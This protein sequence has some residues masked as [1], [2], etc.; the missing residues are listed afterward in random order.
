MADVA[1]A[2]EESGLL[3]FPGE[4]VLRRLIVQAAGKDPETVIWTRS[5]KHLPRIPYYPATPEQVFIYRYLRDRYP[6]LEISRPAFFKGNHH[7]KDQACDV[8]GPRRELFQA[9]AQLFDSWPGGLNVGILK[10]DLH[11]HIDLRR[12]AQGMPVRRRNIEIDKQASGRRWLVSQAARDFRVY[13]E[14][15]AMVYGWPSFAAAAAPSRWP[16]ILLGGAV[17]GL[18]FYSRYRSK[19]RARKAEKRARK[20][21]FLPE[22]HSEPQK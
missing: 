11:M 20:R 8:V 2:P 3:G 6:E 16:L 1:D 4:A 12:D 19:K 14:R 18:Y 21:E 7:R 10:A 13:L 5:V 15:A 9:F 22:Y 17:A